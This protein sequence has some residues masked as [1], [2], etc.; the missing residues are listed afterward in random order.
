MTDWKDEL[1]ALD[2]E[3]QERAAGPDLDVLRTRV[4]RRRAV[5]TVVPSAVAAVIIVVLAS[6]LVPLRGPQPRPAAPVEGCG[7][8]VQQAARTAFGVAE[9]HDSGEGPVT[10]ELSGNAVLDT[11]L[12]STGFG[13]QIRTDDS[14]AL[15][16]SNNTT[17][18]AWLTID[19]EVVAV[20]RPEHV[21]DITGPIASDPMQWFDTGWRVEGCGGQ[22]IEA[23]EY[24]IVAAVAIAPGQDRTASAT[25]VVLSE[26]YG[27]RFEDPDPYRNLG[28]CAGPDWPG[29]QVVED[30]DG[31][32]LGLRLDSNMPTE[33]NRDELS[34]LQADVFVTN[35]S[36]G[37]LNGSTG[38]PVMAVVADGT[39]IGGTQGVLDIALVADFDTDA[40]ITYEA[41]SFL[42]LCD[43]SP[44]PKGTYELY[45]VMEFFFDTPAGED[46]P[47]GDRTDV[48]A[49]GGPWKFTVN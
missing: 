6:I 11:G 37:P 35:R 14:Y 32:K 30:T 16:R 36:G 28:W 22:A 39:V 41:G 47:E 5:R 12:D 31:W 10:F 17:M 7:Q 9:V 42:T 25:A 26:P 33:I 23:G 24:E 46:G 13:S 49:V 38:H 20:L 48:R 2:A 19:G 40:T 15:V 3:G 18:A 29:E 43:G 34:S 44:L 1:S 27:I 45:A 8:T 4:R 21:G